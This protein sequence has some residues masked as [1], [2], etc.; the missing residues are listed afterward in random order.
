[1]NT[2]K[3]AT[4]RQINIIANR[5]NTYSDV[6][7]KHAAVDVGISLFPDSR[8]AIIEAVTNH[9]ITVRWEQYRQTPFPARLE[10]LL[11]EEDNDTPVVDV[12]HTHTESSS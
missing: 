1:M 3:V 8:N 6:I 10:F 2:P 4:R 7:Q 11:P 9:P 5:A 12:S